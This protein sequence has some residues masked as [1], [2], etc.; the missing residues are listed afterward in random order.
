[1]KFYALI[2]SVVLSCNG[3]TYMETAEPITSDS[4]TTQLD[5][6]FSIVDS[7]VQV[8]KQQ[9][10]EKEF[11]IDSLKKEVENHKSTE[12]EP[13]RVVRPIERRVVYDTVTIYVDSLK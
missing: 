2:L 10:H 1:M 12:V 11:V 9:Q 4:S 6:I 7:T 3:G 8:V 13:I 5:S